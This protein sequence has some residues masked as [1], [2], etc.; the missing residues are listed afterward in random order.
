[1]TAI[2]ALIGLSLSILL[3]IR[4]LSPTYSLIIGAI[5]GG[6][7][8]GLSLNETV[9]V[10]T[11]GVKEVTPAVLRILTAGV[12]SGI[13]IQT[14]ATTVISN[15]IINKMGE[16]RVFM[17]LAL[18]TMLLCT[19]GVF[20]DVAVITVAPVALSIGKRLNLSPSVLLIAMI[21]GGKC[22]NIISPN[23]NTIIAAGNFNADLS[24]VMF[25]NIL[26]AVIGLFFTVFVIVHLMPQSVKN[27]KTMMQTEDK[28]EE[29]NLPSLRTSLI[30]PVVTI[31]LLALRPAA[32][33]DSF[34]GRWFMWCYLYETMEKYSSQYRIWTAKD[35]CGSY[36][37]DRNRNYCRYHK[38]LFFERLDSYRIRS[39]SYE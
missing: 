15:A 26:P 38:E 11:E 7:L 14:G 34:A 12:L 3:I 30:A 8:G 33:I 16:K 17:A 20:I 5:V 36:S 28:E 13:L 9:T 29:R 24:A 1:M 2:G 18:A 27:K 25:A 35:V 22:G 21:G 31:V 19:V 39:C 23:P 4:K 10:M 32:G 37:V 6:L